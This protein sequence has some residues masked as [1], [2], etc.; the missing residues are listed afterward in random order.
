MT[1]TL[2]SYDT[3]VAVFSSNLG[4]V[5]VNVADREFDTLHLSPEEFKDLGTPYKITIYARKAS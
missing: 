4:E 5:G 2:Q 1:L 3:G